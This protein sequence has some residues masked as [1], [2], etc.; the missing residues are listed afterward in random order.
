VSLV[1]FDKLFVVE[2]KVF[3]KDF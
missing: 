2:S 3:L 1:Y